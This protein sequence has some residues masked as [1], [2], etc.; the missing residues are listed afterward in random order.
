MFEELFKNKK[1]DAG[2]LKEHGFVE[3]PLG[4]HRKMPVLKGEFL[5][6]VSLCASRLDTRL[7]EVSSGE[8]YALYKTSASGSYVGKIREEIR[9][10]LSSIA[11]NCFVP[12]VFLSPKAQTL[13]GFAESEYG[14]EPEF[15]WEKTPEN[16]VLRRKGGRKW[17]AVIMAIPASK[18]GIPSGE[19][20]EIADLRGDPG[21]IKSL[22]D[23]ESFFP[24][25]HM[26]KRNWYTLLLDGSVQDEE[27]FAL[28][29]ESYR[30]AK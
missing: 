12:S 23:G 7:I 8:E 4:Y 5:L 29:K 17:Y 15:L 16:A 25:W 2:K 26:N 14:D 30:L 27:L 24:A 19:R 1:A 13:L 20:I 11:S 10:E 18:L 9:K 22:L 28:L 6:E 3:T 21:R